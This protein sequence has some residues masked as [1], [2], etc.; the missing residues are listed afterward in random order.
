[1]ATVIT[2]SVEAIII[3]KKRKERGLQHEVDRRSVVCGVTEYIHTVQVTEYR[4]GKVDI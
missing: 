4:V 3:L 1:M 2:A